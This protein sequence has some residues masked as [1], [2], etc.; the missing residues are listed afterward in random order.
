MKRLEIDIVIYHDRTLY[1]QELAKYRTLH[2][3]FSNIVIS[4]FFEFL[5]KTLLFFQ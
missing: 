4:K 2:S 3:H 5:K 1:F